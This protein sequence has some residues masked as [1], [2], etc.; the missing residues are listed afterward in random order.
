MQKQEHDSDTLTDKSIMFSEH[1]KDGSLTQEQITLLKSAYQHVSDA[2]FISD[3]KGKFLLVNDT[4]CSWLGYSA[5]ELCN[6]SVIDIEASFTSNDAIEHQIHNLVANQPVT[7][8]SIH[9]RRDGSTYPVNIT[10]SLIT[11]YGQ[12]FL[13]HCARDIS[14]SETLQRDNTMH[15]RRS[16]ALLDAIP[17]MFFMINREGIITAFHGDERE[18]YTKDKAAIINKPISNILPSYL[19][20]LT[21]DRLKTAL[22]T[23]ETQHYRYSLVIPDTG[24]NFY[25]TRMVRS[26]EDEALVIIRNIT[27]KVKHEHNFALQSRML[28]TIQDGIISTNLYGDIIYA[29]RSMHSLLFRP[30]KELVGKHITELPNNPHSDA[31]QEEII[32]YTRTQGFWRGILAIQ[33]EQQ[34]LLLDTQTYLVKD[35][36]DNPLGVIGVAND[37]TEITRITALNDLIAHTLKNATRSMEFSDIAMQLCAQ[38]DGMLPNRFSSVFLLD[39]ECEMLHLEGYGALA[40]SWAELVSPFPIGPAACSCGTAAYTNSRVIV[41]DIANDPRWEQLRQEAADHQLKACWSEPIRSIDG[42]KVL[43]TFAIYASQIA[44]PSRFEVLLIE[45]IS[46]ILGLIIEQR[47]NRRDIEMRD[48]NFQSLLSNPHGYFIYQTRYNRDT[49]AI[50]VLNVSPSIHELLALNKSDAKNFPSW[51]F[52]IHP[53]DNTR[54]RTSSIRGMMPPFSFD[55]QFRYLH[56]EKGE[57]WLH[58]RANGVPY[59]D[60]PSLIEYANGIILDIT[61]RKNIELELKQSELTFRQL[62]QN[63][64]V[65]CFSFDRDGIILTWN[66]TCEEYYGWTAEDAIGHS[67]YDLIVLPQNREITKQHIAQIFKGTSFEGMEFTDRCADGSHITVLANEYPVNDESGEVLYAVCAELD[68]T[69]RKKAEKSVKESEALLRTL[70]NNLPGGMMLIDDDYTVVQV[71]NTVCEI[72]GFTK[73]ELIGSKCDILC[74]KGS[75]SKQCPIWVDGNIGFEAM[76]TTIKCKNGYRNPIL[77]NARRVT[78]DGREHILEVFQDTRK[79]K[80][81]EIALRESELKFKNMYTHTPVGVALVSLDNQIMQANHA[82]CS[83]LGYTEQE[84]V[85]KTLKDITHPETLPENLALQDKLKHGTIETYELEKKF[86]HKD[87]HT[88]YGLLNAT[89]ITGPDGKPVYCLGNVAD[90]THRKKSEKELRRLSVR[91]ALAASSAQIGIWELDL[92]TNELIWDDMMF[93]LYQISPEEF[94]ADYAAWQ[95]PLHPEDRERAEAEVMAAINAEKG[96]DTSFRIIHPDGSVHTLKAYGVVERDTT[97]KPVK[98]TGVNYD[99]TSDIEHTQEIENN[100]REK[101]TLLQ[102]IHHRVK[103][104]MQIIISLLRLQSPSFTDSRS[105]QLY[106]ECQQRIRSMAL[107]HEKLYRSTDLININFAGYIGDLANQLFHAYAASDSNIELR[108]D[109]APIHLSIEKAIPCGLVLNELITNSLKYAFNDEKQEVKEITIELARADDEMVIINYWDNGCGLPD[110]FDPTTSDSLGFKLITLLTRGQL[111]GKIRFDNE[112]GF[113][114]GMKFPLL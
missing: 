3:M 92:T 24:E 35:N 11:L 38:L 107:V 78:I 82:F 48:K 51:F 64:P 91:L 26:L 111:K 101:E 87:G 30:H 98:I 52:H 95:G 80:A 104:N 12:Q 93:Q 17:D 62:F 113:G 66:A 71:N 103:N 83:M 49:K 86:T 106:R 54:I 100:L 13:F 8:G 34:E 1:H 112:S 25:E 16:E 108:L 94:T 6:L 74:P 21:M 67:I 57:L 73:D 59:A 41:T 40:E 10:I 77:K 7:F 110:D 88:V 53:E 114:F 4:A 84:L 39:E 15:H 2:I 29:N 72:T 97:G 58:V 42:S 44:T 79:N 69:E 33:R 28:D 99:I 109:I 36:D 70:Y 75:K 37:V 89:A 56:P 61:H 65:G 23:G 5:Q 76:D 9:K 102:E 19:V 50:E 43:G 60:D 47:L 27:E 90:I 45:S 96:F 32:H 55:E 31:T 46:E 22:E 63:I 68:I 105:K 20:T 14:S 85:G 18:L 81:D